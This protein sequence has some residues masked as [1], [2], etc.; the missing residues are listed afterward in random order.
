MPNPQIS[1]E[2]VKSKTGK[3]WEEWF[4]LLDESGCLT[5]DHKQIVD[6]VK[7]KFHVQ[8]WWQQ[9]ITVSYEQA[10]GKRIL[11]ERPEGFQIS[12]SITFNTVIEKAYT[13]WTDETVREKW[14]ADPGITIRKATKNHSLRITWVDGKSSVDVSFAVKKDKAQVVINH[15]KLPDPQKAEEMKKYWA[16]QL[17]KL[18]KLLE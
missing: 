1:N 7:N 16:D 11:N 18:A 10:R 3:T 8:S 14:L 5:M 15:S 4:T 12:K 9:M 2:A 6:V 17:D 13:A